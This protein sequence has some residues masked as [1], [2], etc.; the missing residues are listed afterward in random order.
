[1]KKVAIFLIILFF[2]FLNCLTVK[3]TNNKLIKKTEISAKD[4]TSDINKN[5][6]PEKEEIKVPPIIE[7]NKN[8]SLL[9]DQDI[10]KSSNE[11]FAKNEKNTAIKD[12]EKQSDSINKNKTKKTSLNKKTNSNKAADD[13]TKKPDKII[14]IENK[15]NDPKK[16]E[17][18][19]YFTYK[20]EVKEDKTVTEIINSNMQKSAE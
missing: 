5:F 9:F 14:I 6:I 18:E 13:S 7:E 15:Q 17:Q 20:N 3:N 1:M 2:F 11:V 19:K 10:K 12:N 4:N 8:Y 16:E